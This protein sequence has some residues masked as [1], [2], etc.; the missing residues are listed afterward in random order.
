M[1]NYAFIGR[2][3][4]IDQK[5][6]IIGY[7]LLYRHSAE[8]TEAT[9]PDEFAACANIL[10]NT[11]T[12]MGT[13][14]LLG[15]GLAFINV[16]P[17]LLDSDILN[18]LPGD[19]VV[20]ELGIGIDA[21][22]TDLQRHFRRLRGQ[23]F[24]I[25]LEDMLPG[26]RTLPLTESVDFIKLDA[27]LVDTST[28]AN[29]IERYRDYPVQLIAKKVETM[30]EFLACA[31][32]GFHYFQG[33][34]FAHPETLSVKT[35]NPAQAVVLDLLN[36]VRSNVDVAELEASFKQDVALS[37]KL[38]RFINSVG[39]GLNFHIQSIHHALTL[40]GYRQLYRWL[41]LLLITA[42]NGAPSPALIKTAIIK[43]RFT[44]LLGQ[45][46]LEG[47]ERDNLFIVG[48]FS[49]LD[50]ILEMPMANVLETVNLPEN[51][52]A[53]LLRREGIYAP[54]LE[55]AEACESMDWEGVERMAETL[56]LPPEK[57]NQ[58]HLDALAWVEKLELA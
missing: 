31:E 39:F 14:W 16:T 55:L 13:E 27:R 46:Y 48:V 5:Q 58:S 36:K 51:I 50:A 3:P 21:D 43:G 45:D 24:R 47:S 23:G 17:A 57:I 9:I 52:A 7:E 18:L 38:L 41:T 34:H 29:A 11:L 8:A 42:S 35:I 54:F 20:L 37:L 33:F 49:L 19:R 30:K 25:A 12:N 4:I 10:A 28:L 6:R 40:L 15:N 53:A 56:G 1:G 22:L 32:L 2:Q 44:E 26:K